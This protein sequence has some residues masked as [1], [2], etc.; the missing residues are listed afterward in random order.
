M[1]PARA[2]ASSR[3]PAHPLQ[4]ASRPPMGTRLGLSIN[5]PVENPD[6]SNSVDTRSPAV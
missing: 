5:A 6:T 4:S 3:P 1:I 2:A